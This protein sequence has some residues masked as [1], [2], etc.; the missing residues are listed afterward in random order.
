[1][2][3]LILKADGYHWNPDRTPLLSNYSNIYAVRDN[4]VN[5]F[6][7]KPFDINNDREQKSCSILLVLALKMLKV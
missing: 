2:Q 6:Y 1:M 3:F 7:L 4:Y 5:I